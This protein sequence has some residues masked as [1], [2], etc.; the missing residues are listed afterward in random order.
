MTRSQRPRSARRRI[1][2]GAAL[3]CAVALALV[4][5]VTFTAQAAALWSAGAPLDPLLMPM[6][7]FGVASVVTIVLVVLVGWFVAGAAL[8]SIAEV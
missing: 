5:G 4:G 6:T 8:R 1:V 3:A 2:T 7:V